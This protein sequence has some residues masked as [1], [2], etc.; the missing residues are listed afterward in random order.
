LERVEQ[1]LLLAGREMIVMQYRP[2]DASP[3]L[4][5]ARGRCLC[6]ASW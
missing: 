6:S 3:D 4:G 5:T 1:E 2:T